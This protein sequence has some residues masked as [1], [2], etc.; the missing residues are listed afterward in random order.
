MNNRRRFIKSIAGALVASAMPK[1][2]LNAEP[3][4]KFHEPKTIPT[5]GLLAHIEKHKTTIEWSEI[6]KNKRVKKFSEQ[7]EEAMWLG[8]S[9][10][11]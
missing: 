3:I 6:A 2:I 10:I 8:N 9:N 11:K 7:V 4:V 5:T 1:S